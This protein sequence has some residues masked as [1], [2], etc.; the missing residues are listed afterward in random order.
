MFSGLVGDF[1]A[2]LLQRNKYL[3]LT[4]MT[5]VYVNANHT[6]RVVHRHDSHETVASSV[7]SV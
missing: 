5:D 3:N 2:V 7:T 1:A 4:L 6:T